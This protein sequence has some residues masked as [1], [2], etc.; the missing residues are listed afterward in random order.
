[1]DFASFVRSSVTDEIPLNASFIDALHRM[2]DIAISPALQIREGLASIV[3]STPALLRRNFRRH[4]VGELATSKTL[5]AVAA[6]L[7]PTALKSQLILHANDEQR[8]SNIFGALA[9]KLA[10]YVGGDERNYEAIL[11]EDRRFVEGYTGDIVEFICD[12]FAGEV[13]T[14]S[15]LLGYVRALEG[16]KPVYAP[17]VESILKAIIEDERRHISYTATYIN[18][19]MG[20]GLDLQ[21]SLQRGFSNFDRTSWADVVETAEFFVQRT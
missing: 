12:L 10:E 7:K 11:E 5:D 2:D 6:S 21:R 8:H 17:K 4:S 18:E 19:W 16:K 1:M 3:V 15:F 14:C 9:D 13:R 20:G